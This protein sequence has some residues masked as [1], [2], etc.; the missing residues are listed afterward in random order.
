MLTPELAAH[1]RYNT[2]HYQFNLTP[3][4]G[5]FQQSEGAKSIVTVIAYIPALPYPEGTCRSHMR[6]AM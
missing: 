5:T 3:H 1:D 2:M 4:W 6:A